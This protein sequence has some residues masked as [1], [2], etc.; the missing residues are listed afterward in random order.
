MTDPKEEKMIDDTVAQVMQNIKNNKTAKEQEEKLPFTE[1]SDTD[2]K[3]KHFAR[4]VV[5]VAQIIGK[6]IFHP[7]SRWG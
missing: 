4:S 7:K 2:G 5:G 3:I 6:I 1:Y